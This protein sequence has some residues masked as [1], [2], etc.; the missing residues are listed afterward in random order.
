MEALGRPTELQRT[1]ANLVVWSRRAHT[2]LVTSFTICAIALYRLDWVRLWAGYFAAIIV[3]AA[4]W[5]AAAVE[6]LLVPVP[7]HVVGRRERWSHR[8]C[9]CLGGLALGL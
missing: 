5:V 7:Q 6:A 8:W 2:V 3:V 9:E 1:D 4:F